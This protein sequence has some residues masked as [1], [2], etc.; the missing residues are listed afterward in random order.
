MIMG[1]KKILLAEDD[2]DD[3]LLFYDFIKERDD[4]VLQHSTENGME[5]IDY[6]EKIADPSSFPD[7]IVLDQNMPKMNGYQTLYSLKSNSR[8]ASIP[9]AIYT[10]YSDKKLIEDSYA[11]GALVVLE[12]PISPSGYHQ[13]MNEF[14]MLIGTASHQ[15]L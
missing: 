6:L 15:H 2:E 12:K 8:Y 14:V 11:A 4:M 1:T 3:R 5:I 13:M 7:L 9:V 10:T